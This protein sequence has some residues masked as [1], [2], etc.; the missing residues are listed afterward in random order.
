MINIHM[1]KHVNYYYKIKL[2]DNSVT[3]K[4]WSNMLLYL[5]SYIFNNNIDYNFLTKY[6]KLIT[7]DIINEYFNNNNYSNDL[8]VLNNLINEYVGDFTLFSFMVNENNFLTNY[9]IKCHKNN[10]LN[11]VFNII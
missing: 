7:C 1:N 9:I 10:N 8:F 11:L 3:M 5:I 6:D 4:S 2:N